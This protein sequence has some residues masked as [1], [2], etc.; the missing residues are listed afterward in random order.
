MS[1]ER[2]DAIAAIIASLIAGRLYH[3]L[4]IRRQCFDYS[5]ARDFMGVH[6]LGTQRP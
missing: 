1:S 3:T 5:R 4:I 6:F 2:C